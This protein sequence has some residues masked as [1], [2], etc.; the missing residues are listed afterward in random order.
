ML[1]ASSVRP[2]PI[3]PAMPTIS[4]RRTVRLASSTTARWWSCG[5]MT[6]QSRTSS[7]TSPICGVWSGNRCSRSRPTMPRMIRSSSTPPARTSR[8]SIVRPSRRIVIAS[9]I[10]SISFSLWLIMIEVMPLCLQAP[11]QVEQVG[12][13]VVVQRRGRLVQDEQLHLLAQRLGDLDQLLLADAEVL[14]RGQRVLPQPDAGQQLDGPVVGLVPVDDP[15]GRGLVAEEDVLGDRQLRDQRQLLV[16]DHDAC[17]L[18]L[19]EV[20]ERTPARPRRRC[21]R[22]RSRAGRPRSAPSSASTCP[23]RSHRRSRGSRPAPR[24]G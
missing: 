5:C 4:P 2:A 23:R 17:G 15:A 11:E 10:R 3:R 14:D 18:A 13:V 1:R 12:R 6:V 8:V 21:R 16:D 7:S 24:S 9:A 20:L 22:R 19:P